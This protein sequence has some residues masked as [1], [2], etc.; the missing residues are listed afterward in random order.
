VNRLLQTYSNLVNSGVPYTATVLPDGTIKIVLD[1]SVSLTNPSFTVSI[2]DPSKITTENGAHLQSLTSAIE[3]IML[4][5]YPAGTTSDAPLVV[6]GTILAILMLLV[7]GA[8][9]ICS[10]VPIY[11]SV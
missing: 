4:N 9:F 5:A 2:N 3:N 8:V 1:P 11:H 10:P 6:A 7:L